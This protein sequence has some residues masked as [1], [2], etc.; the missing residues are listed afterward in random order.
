M[1][2]RGIPPEGAPTL[3]FVG[4]AGGSIIGGLP[5]RQGD[6]GPPGTGIVLKGTVA[7]YA[8]LPGGATDG[9]AYEVLADGKLYAS[10]AGVWPAN[11]AGI[12]FRGPAGA[13]GTDGVDGTGTVA[14]LVAGNNIDI[15]AT[16][17][18]M[19]IVSVEVLTPADIGLAATVTELDYVDGVTSPIQAQINAKQ[20]ADADL[21]ALAALTAPATKLS[22]IEAGATANSPDATLLAR[23]NH[24]GTQAAATINDFS[25]AADARITAASL[26]RPSG[27]DVAVADGGT[28][29]STT[30]GARTN[31]GLSIGADVQAYD[32]DLA[33]IAALTA[34]TGNFLVAVASAWA[35]QTPAQVRTLLALV[36]GTNVQA[37]DTDLDAIAALAAANDDVI[38]RKAGVWATRTLAQLKTDLALNLV[39]NTSNA[40]ERA[41][42]ATLAGKTLT[43]P[44]ITSYVETVVPIGTVTTANTIS[45]TSG[46]VQTATLT[47]STACTFTMPT[48]V[49][50]KSF[51]V[52]L[53]QPSTT[54]LGTATFTS[55]KWPIAGAPTI[56]PTAGKMDILT[57]VADGTNWYGSYVQGFTY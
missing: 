30:S 22:G 17:P 48:N 38:Q 45:L 32:T 26:Y 40:T 18:T 39:D 14:G 13:P 27:T 11:G 20:A 1:R 43:N 47:A 19:P 28:G 37:W 23:A 16:D 5:G 42:T 31:L 36:I 6:P 3:S 25:T 7:T 44:T 9:D 53:K 46:T 33:A 29:A 4:S 54:G 2:L 55:V 56:T 10:A 49:A 50:G 51:V 34:T 57:F 12:P 24:T 8:A 35:S 15:D 21:T 52:L 41:A